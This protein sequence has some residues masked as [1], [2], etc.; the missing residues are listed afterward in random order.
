V[1]INSQLHSVIIMIIIIKFLLNIVELLFA[2]EVDKLIT[3]GVKF[4][5]D[6]VY[7]KL[8]KLTDLSQNYS[9]IKG[10]AF[11]GINIIPLHWRSK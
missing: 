9:K 5:Q 2:G 1:A 8:L 7:Q 3:F 10:G 11:I 6:V 4:L